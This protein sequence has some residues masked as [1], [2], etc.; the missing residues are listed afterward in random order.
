[1]ISIN[2]NNMKYAGGNSKK[3]IMKYNRVTAFLKN[4]FI[5]DTMNIKK[6]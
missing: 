1:M 6:N 2:I 3:Y 5:I 4:K